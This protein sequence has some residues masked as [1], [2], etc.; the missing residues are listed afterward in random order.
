[1]RIQ[2]VL[3]LLFIYAGTVYSASYETELLSKGKSLM[4]QNAYPEAINYFNTINTRYT[5][6]PLLPESLNLTAKCYYQLGDYRHALQFYALSDKSG[7]SEYQKRQSIFGIALSYF[8]LKD[9]GRAIPYFLYFG[10]KF[11]DSPV[12]GSAFYYAG[13]AFEYLGRSAEALKTYQELMVRY[14]QS[15]YYGKALERVTALDTPRR[16]PRAEFSREF[17]TDDSPVAIERPKRTSPNIDYYPE[18]DE[19]KSADE[20][21][22]P[23]V[24]ET[25][26]YRAID[27]ARVNRTETLVPDIEPQCVDEETAETQTPTKIDSKNL[28]RKN[29]GLSI[30]GETK[31]P[32]LL[33][34]TN[35]VTVTNRT[36]YRNPD[37]MQRTITNKV[38][39]TQYVQVK[40]LDTNAMLLDQVKT[41]HRESDEEV[42]RFRSLL[43]MKAKLLNLKEQAIREKEK[44]L[45]ETNK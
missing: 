32:E 38:V 3:A 23:I 33:L 18:S 13:T 5:T 26:K 27:T 4:N 25:A 31:F 41:E 7:G 8:Q 11:T 10:Q 22:I 43:E 24:R 12:A 29:T 42:D 19:T 17:S 1:M 39:L 40:I 2:L 44:L 15:S 21:E 9:Y 36:V 20:I 35:Y 30:S 6:S 14:P 34:M 16:L 37:T 28:M 45:M